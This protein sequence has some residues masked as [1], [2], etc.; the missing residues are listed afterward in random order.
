MIK[1]RSYLA[2]ALLVAA[3]R[4]SLSPTPASI[5]SGSRADLRTFIDSMADAPEFSNAHWG[6][7]IV[8]PARG[9]IGRDQHPHVA[10][11]EVR[12]RLQRE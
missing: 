5:S 8:D 3:C 6:I 11:L 7:L 4:P 2:L 1:A 12:Q 9:D 10:G